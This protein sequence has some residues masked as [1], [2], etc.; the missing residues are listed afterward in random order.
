MFSCSHQ[1]L[2]L[3]S[4]KA[5]SNAKRVGWPLTEVGEGLYLTQA[6]GGYPFYLVDKEQPSSGECPKSCLL[7]VQL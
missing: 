2:T 4:N 7:G 3:Q 5:V 6:P 1:G